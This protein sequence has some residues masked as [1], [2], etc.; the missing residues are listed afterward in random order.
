M[1]KSFMLMLLLA[2]AMGSLRRHL[3]NSHKWFVKGMHKRHPYTD[4]AAI[5]PKKI[6]VYE[7]MPLKQA[8]GAAQFETQ[9]WHETKAVKCNHPEAYYNGGEDGATGLP[10]YSVGYGLGGQRKALT[11]RVKGL[12]YYSR[13]SKKACS[14]KGHCTCNE[15]K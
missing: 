1:M 7:D 9:Y 8:P 4:G 2:L 11:P 13:L 10:N 15:K 5:G 6:K 12:R 3:K 14:C